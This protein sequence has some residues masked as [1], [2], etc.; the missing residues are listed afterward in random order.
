VA[1]WILPSTVILLIL[2]SAGSRAAEPQECRAA[3]GAAAAGQCLLKNRLTEIDARLNEVYQNALHVSSSDRRR[4]L[5]EAQR[6]WI[7]FRDRECGTAE[8][9]SRADRDKWLNSVAA[10]RA[11]FA[12]VVRVTS[13][14]TSELE[15]RF[16]GA[17]QRKPRNVE[18]GDILFTEIQ[19][20]LPESAY[21]VRSASAHRGGHYYFEVTVDHGAIHSTLEADLQLRIHGERDSAGTTYSIRPQNQ[22][23]RA[24]ESGSITIVGGSSL[25]VVLGVAVDLDGRN[26]SIHRNGVWEDSTPLPSGQYLF[27]EVSSSVS[28]SP[29]IAGKIVDVNFGE[30]P[31]AYPLRLGYAPYDAAMPLEPPVS[32]SEVPALAPA[33]P[34][35]AEPLQNVIQRYW[36]WVRSFPKGETPSDDTTGVRCNAGQTGDIF[37][38]T[39]STG[40][41]PVLR[42]CVVPRGVHLFVPILNVLGQQSARQLATCADLFPPVR[43][44]NRSATG[45]SLKLNGLPLASPETYSA[46]S[47]CFQLQDSSSGLLGPAAGAGYWVLLKPL[48][49]G[50]YDLQFGGT[51]RADGFSQDVRYRLRVTP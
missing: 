20:S 15:A 32:L 13:I 48:P 46:E 2:I 5:R 4:E 1:Q 41:A 43:Q 18:G 9:T 19:P 50:T 25:R 10:D 42:T 17:N 49:P 47:G 35:Q 22:V 14:R 12:C 27:A 45:L 36:R 8:G 44:V 3:S 51:Y 21:R 40:T 38:L 24:G 26:W 37:F 28:M 11:A 31:F 33:A 30:R 6:L 16:A 23:V 7:S 29:L 34:V 39:G